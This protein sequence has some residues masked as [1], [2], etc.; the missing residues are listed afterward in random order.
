MRMIRL[1]GSTWDHPRGYAPMPVT[2]A[3]YQREHPEVEIVWE[4][5][6]LHDFGHANVEE[7][8]KRYDLV[9]LDHPWAGFIASHRCF[10]PLDKLVAKDAI[11]QLAKHSVGP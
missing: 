3:A 4:K 2:A 5:R 7:L 1:T 6:S 10:Y 8:S 9:V 11:D